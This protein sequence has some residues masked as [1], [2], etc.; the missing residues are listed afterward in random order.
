MTHINTVAAPTNNATSDTAEPVLHLDPDVAA[1]FAEIDAILCAA[2]EPARRPP[3]PPATGCALLE[4]R[5]AGWSWGVLVR[6]Q[7]G[8]VHPVRA[9]QRSPPTHAR[10]QHRKP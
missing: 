10:D 7:A 9:V 8:P 2:L 4:P 6:P 3:A 1:L 5:S